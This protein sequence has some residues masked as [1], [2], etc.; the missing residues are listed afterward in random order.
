MKLLRAVQVGLLSQYK[1]TQ[2][3]IIKIHFKSLLW[4]SFEGISVNSQECQGGLWSPCEGERV[5]RTPHGTRPPQ[6]HQTL[7]E[8]QLKHIFF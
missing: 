6:Q 8:T 5:S 1:Y 4:S 2:K 3:K 7:L